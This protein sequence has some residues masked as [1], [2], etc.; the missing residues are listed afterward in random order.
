MPPFI[1]ELPLAFAALALPPAPTQLAQTHRCRD[2]AA[3]IADCCIHLAFLEEGR[4]G[5]VQPRAARPTSL[6]ERAVDHAENR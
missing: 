2:A 4:V 1:L 5:V 6:D 3:A